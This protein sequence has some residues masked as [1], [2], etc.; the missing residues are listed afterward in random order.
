VAYSVKFISGR[1]EVGWEVIFTG[2]KVVRS[3]EI[4]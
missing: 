1:F 2:A 4:E 3:I